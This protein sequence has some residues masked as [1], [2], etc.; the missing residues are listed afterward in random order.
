MAAERRTS[1]LVYRLAMHRN[2]D[3]TP[4]N[5]KDTKQPKDPSR[6]PGLSTTAVPGNGKLNQVIDLA[7]LKE[8][9]R[10][11]A[12]ADNHVAIVPVNDQGEIDRE[13]LEEWASYREKK[14][15]HPLTQIMLDAIVGQV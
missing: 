12:D 13:K 6:L 2:K 15:C 8:P 10:A 11:F 4:R 9:L 3:F 5:P 1:G 14:E 7:R